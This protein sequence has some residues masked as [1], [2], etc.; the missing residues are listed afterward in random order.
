[1]PQ[2]VFNTGSLDV[3][4]ASTVTSAITA[5][6]L[7]SYGVGKAIDIDQPF[8]LVIQHPVTS[9]AHHRAHV[10]A[11]LQAVAPLRIPT[12]WI[13]PNADAGTGE[14][15]E[16]LRHFREHGEGRDT[17]MRFITDVPVDE[18]VALL[19]RTAC[20]VG[21]SSAGIKECSYLG[22]PAVNVGARQ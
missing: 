5:E 1:D 11:T 4:L 3:E 13:W 14:I 19:K 9:E 22:T 17:P 15:A 2:Y 18:F 10:E 8:V 20:L 21:N 7:N 12:I 6:R 16:R